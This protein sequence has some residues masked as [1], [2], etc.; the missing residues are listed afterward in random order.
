MLHNLSQIPLSL[1]IITG[2]IILFSASIIFWLIKRKFKVSKIQIKTGP[3]KTT[4]KPEQKHKKNISTNNP[5]VQPYSVNINGNKL[6]GWSKI[7]VRRERTQIA[8]N[9]S[10][11]KTEIEV[12]SKPG[13]KPKNL[14]K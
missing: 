9:L 3:I 13:P 5:E 8:D 1:W 11:G 4:L 12:G 14:S 2:V 10:I 6:F 7:G